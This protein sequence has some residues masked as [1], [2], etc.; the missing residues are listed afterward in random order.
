MKT[1]SAIAG[2]LATAALGAAATGWILSSP[3]A[4][5]TTRIE[6]NRKAPTRHSPKASTN[7]VGRARPLARMGNPRGQS[8]EARAAGRTLYLQLNCAGC[9][10]YHG[11]GNM[12]PQLSDKYWLFGGTPAEIYQSVSLGRPKGMPAWGHAL[13]PQSRWE[14]VAYLD[15][16]GGVIPPGMADAARQ[17]DF[18]ERGPDKGKGT[19]PGTAGQSPPT[20][21]P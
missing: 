9:H 21:S 19:G 4:L 2:M 14:L 18:P 20:T 13:P 10:C 11:E 7:P 17:G 5:Q 16:L 3:N 8:P 15:S 1:A 12:G 6:H